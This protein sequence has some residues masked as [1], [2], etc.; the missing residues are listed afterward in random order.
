MKTL[1]YQIRWALPLWFVGLLTNWLPDNRAVCRLRGILASPFI[2]HCGRRVRLGQHVTLGGSN[3]LSIGDDV[4]LAQ[5]VWLN[6]LMGMT[7]EDE[8]I[9][10][11]YVVI[12]TAQHVFRDGS[13]RFGGS[14]GGAVRIGRGAWLAAHSTV[15]CGV[16]VGEGSLVAA[17][18]A[19]TKDVPPHTIV[20]GVPAKILGEN[21]DSIASFFTRNQIPSA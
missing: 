17:N 6:A 8:V 15:K 7:V 1:W 5:G 10:G 21:H 11:P 9:M 20:G 12:S 16:H 14:I 4:Y 13:V 2:G 3:R 19:V 18:A